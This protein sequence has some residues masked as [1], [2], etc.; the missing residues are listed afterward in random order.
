MVASSGSACTRRI[1]RCCARCSSDCLI[2]P[3]RTRCALVSGRSSKSM[4]TRCR[5]AHGCIRIPIQHCLSPPPA[6]QWLA[7]PLGFPR[8]AAQERHACKHPRSRQ[9]PYRKA[10]GR[11]AKLCYMGHATMENRHG[12]AVAGMVTLANGTAERRASE[13]M[14]KAKAKQAGRP[15][16][17]SG[18]RQGL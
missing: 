18:R 13:M 17:H 14:L 10:A 11:E 3:S 6:T 12:L 9:P 5:A 16:H 4:R 8:T 2:S 7:A 1:G 15:P